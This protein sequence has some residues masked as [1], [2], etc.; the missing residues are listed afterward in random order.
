MVYMILM[1]AAAE[2]IA[3]KIPLLKLPKLKPLALPF[4]IL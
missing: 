3:I 2:F 4:L 1:T